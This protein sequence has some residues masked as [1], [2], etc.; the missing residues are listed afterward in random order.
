MAT[1]NVL[2]V[3]N[4]PVCRAVINALLTLQPPFDAC[5]YNLSVLT[6]PS[7]TTNLP[8][9]VSTA[10]VRHVTSDFTRAALQSAFAGQDIILSTVAGGDSELQ[11]RVV[12]ALRAV[13]VRRFIPDEF[14]HDSLNKLLQ[15]RLP[16]HAERAR[17][18]H[19]LEK[20]SQ[21]DPSFEWAAITT[22][23]TLDTKLISGDMGLDLQ[24]HSATVHGTGTEQFAASSLAR[25]GQVVACV[26]THWEGIKNQ[27]IYA[28]GAVTSANEVVKAVEKATGKD[29]T[30]GNY[31]VEE[32][33]E[34]GRKRIQRG[35]P[36]FRHCPTRAQCILR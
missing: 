18:I 14:S 28:A 15:T 31:H 26:L 6:Y 17:V 7:R 23:Y 20:I 4:G 21:A 32:C 25:V 29:F 30:V 13:G 8:P 36:D 12:D 9:H 16:K 3:G 34:E 33:I 35:Y 27:Y 22:G 2:I 19:Y 1:T 5:N 11:I 24:W 10:H